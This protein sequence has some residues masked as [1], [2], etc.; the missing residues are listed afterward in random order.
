MDH[1]VEIIAC[2][3]RLLI[4]RL[5]LKARQVGMSNAVAIEAIHKAITKPDRKSGAKIVPLPQAEL[6]YQFMA[7]QGS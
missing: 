7:T 5:I 2:G 4:G 1:G 6:E 3:R